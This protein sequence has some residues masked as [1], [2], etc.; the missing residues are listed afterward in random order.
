MRICDT[1]TKTAR[2]CLLGVLLA[3]SASCRRSA[4]EPTV[5]LMGAEYDVL[6]AYVTDKFAGPGEKLVGKSKVKIVI[7]NMTQPN[8]HELA[9]LSNGQPVPWTELTKSL[10]KD[11]P[12]L[13]PATVDAYRAANAQQASLR[14]VLQSMTDYELVDSE[15]LDSMFKRNGGGWPAYY[16]QHPA[17]QGILTFS[18]VGFSAD[19][20]QAFLYLSNRCGDLCGGGFYVVM[21]KRSGRWAI[22]REIEN[23]VS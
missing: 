21:E 8:D 3:V 19:G 16:K 15:Q 7:L 17:S 20:T 14:P 2:V 4:L 22:V 10:L 12:D 5:E 9:P 1:R 11:A 13:Q 18:R 6:S 23:S